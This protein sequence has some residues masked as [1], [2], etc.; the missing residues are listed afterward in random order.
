MTF[1]TRIEKFSGFIGFFAEVFFKRRERGNNEKA[2]IIE[3]FPNRAEIGI[4]RSDVARRKKAFAVRRICN[5][6]AVLLGR[7]E[8]T[9]V[10][11]AEI[12]RIGNACAR[13][14][15]TGKRYGV[16]V[17]VESGKRE[18]AKRKFVILCFL[19]SEGISGGVEEIPFG[20][21]ERTVSSRSN[22]ESN[23]CCF[24]ENCAASAERVAKRTVG[25]KVA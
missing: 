15:P 11:N 6:A 22:P 5:D 14:V 9:Y 8:R 25:R 3:I 10:A 2:P 7:R 4:K 13:G 16:G 1:D 18:F 21:I 24:D 19:K 17:Y 12:K 23:A 20:K